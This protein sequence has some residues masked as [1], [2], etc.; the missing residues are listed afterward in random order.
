MPVIEPLFIFLFTGIVSMSAALSAGA[1]N[2]MPEED[3]PAIA[4]SRNGLMAIVLAGNVAAVA[5]L[6]SAAYG[7]YNLDWYIPLACVFIS[8]PVV[9]LVA[10]QPMLGDVK[11][12]FVMSPLALLSLPV[13]YL[14]W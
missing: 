14:Y 3:K 12:L 7:F 9:H 13:L 6:F 8:F 1:I 4:N 11:A 5:L 10:I 2:K